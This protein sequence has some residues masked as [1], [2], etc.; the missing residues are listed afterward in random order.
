MK[1]AANLS[2]LYAELPFLDRFAA[3]AADG[4]TAVEIQFPYDTPA[5]VIRQ[6][7]DDNGQICVLINVPAGDL[8]QGG[9]GLACVPGK[10]SEFSDALTLC[11][12]YV[13][14][15]RPEKVN[16]L[17]GRCFQPERR[18]EYY[19]VFLDNLRRAS[20][21]L[22][23]MG[24]SVTFEAINTQD[25]PGFLIST[26]M[27]MAQVLQDLP[28][29][30]ISMQFDIYHMAMMG[31]ALEQSLTRHITDIGH[32]QFA[33][34]PGRHEPGTGQLDFARIFG[35]LKAL[36]YKGW[37]AAEYRSSLPSTHDGMAWKSEQIELAA[38]RR[39]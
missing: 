10:E 20:E 3:A 35:C 12:Q 19:S 9:E 14:V 36:G 15:L 26:V 38:A 2:M 5:Q 11:Q 6:T 31:E 18:Q 27:E 7:L 25:M 22:T 39:L 23:P 37:L 13:D 30:A 17:A 16:V 1:L 24:V 32:I 29:V 21:V 28:G 34:V 4:F 8:M 33:D